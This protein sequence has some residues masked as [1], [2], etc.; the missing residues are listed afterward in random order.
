MPNKA[1]Q[2]TPG[3]RVRAVRRVPAL[4]GILREGGAAERQAVRPLIRGTDH[5]RTQASV[6][7]IEVDALRYG[8]RA[9]RSLHIFWRARH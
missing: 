1:L 8:I 3:D 9:P 6:E 5:N 7:P 2:P 4:G